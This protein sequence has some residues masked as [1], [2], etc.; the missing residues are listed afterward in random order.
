VA[1]PVLDAAFRLV[2]RQPLEQPLSWR[3]LLLGSGYQGAGWLLFSVPVILVARDLGGSGAHLTVLCVAAFTVSWLAGFLFVLAPAGAG[4]RET[5]LVAL[6]GSTLTAAPAL[7]VAL[8]SRLVMT[9]ADV[10]V[11]GIALATIGRDRIVRLRGRSDE[12]VAAGVSGGAD[13]P[14]T[15]RPSPDRARLGTRG[16][17]GF[18]Q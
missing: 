13:Q 12:A 9:L 10:I 16:E 4:V 5:L 11:G 3:G 14:A 2:R 1:N 6:L 7:T 8:I 15:I 17:N 18:G